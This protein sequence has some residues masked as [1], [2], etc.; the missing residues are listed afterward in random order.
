MDHRKCIIMTYT[1]FFIKF[2]IYIVIWK[3]KKTFINYSGFYLK[4]YKV[5]HLV[6]G[7]CKNVFSGYIV[8]DGVINSV[9]D[10]SLF[11]SSIHCSTEATS[12]HQVFSK[13]LQNENVQKVSRFNNTHPNV[14]YMLQVPFKSKYILCLTESLFFILYLDPCQLLLRQQSWGLHLKHANER[15][16][17][18]LYRTLSRQGKNQM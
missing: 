9:F 11:F 5:S 1:L 8:W 3:H 6:C 10:S 13:L 12:L 14:G 2:S 17:A 16:H 4:K 7:A 15:T 18:S